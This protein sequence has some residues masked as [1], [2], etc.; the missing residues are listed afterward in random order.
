MSSSKNSSKKLRQY[1]SASSYRVRSCFQKLG[2]VDGSRYLFEI[3]NKNDWLK[4][5]NFNIPSK[6]TSFKLRLPKVKK[7]KV[8]FEWKVN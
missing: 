1:F 2:K 5:G 3:V 8:Y 7:L 4:R 6:W